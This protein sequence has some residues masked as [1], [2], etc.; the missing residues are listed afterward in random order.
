MTDLLSAESIIVNLSNQI[1]FEWVAGKKDPKRPL[2][3][4]NASQHTLV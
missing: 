2:H 4:I 1:E 3:E